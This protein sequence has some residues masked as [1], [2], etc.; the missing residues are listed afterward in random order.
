MTLE[1]FQELIGIHF[2]NP[3]LLR[4]AMTHRSYVNEQSD[5]HLG[6]NE[7][8]EFLGDAVLDFV[9]TDMLY[10]QFPEMPEGEL[11]RLR[12]AL[13]RTDALAEL[14]AQCRVGEVLLI[15]KGEGKSGG[16]FRRNNLCSAFEA[17]IGAIFLDQSI[18]Q[19]K[20]FVLPR[21][22]DYLNYVIE[23]A[24]HKDARSQLQEWSQAKLNLTPVYHTID[25][26]GPDHEKEFI[27]E[28]SVGEQIVGRGMGKSKQ[29]AAQA[30]ARSALKALQVIEDVSG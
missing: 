15:G 14:G 21:M 11:T 23:E 4:Q 2:N 9:V 6:D 28:V 8:M 5:A 16:R 26:T 1:E 29:R 24:L 22:A 12:A 18:E 17:L 30:A 25:S 7:R 20:G 3:D 10:E 19:V 27:I 13:V